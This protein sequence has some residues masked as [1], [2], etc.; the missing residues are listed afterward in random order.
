MS[1]W[2]QES[3]SFPQDTDVLDSILSK[4]DPKP[5]P[6]PKKAAS[7]ATMINFFK[8]LSTII[9]LFGD[10]AFAAAETCK[11]VRNLLR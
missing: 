4:M 8:Q 1:P 9:L 2:A 7:T 6:M 5:D 10:P 11:G 3:K